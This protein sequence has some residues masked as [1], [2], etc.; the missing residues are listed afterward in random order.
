MNANSRYRRVLVKLSG[1][2]LMG[3]SRDTFDHR[4]MDGL[5]RELQAAHVAG[6]ELAL[7]V[8]GGNI[9]RGG[10]EG[11]RGLE[12]AR[13]DHMGMLATVINSLAIQ[14]ALAS[15]G[16]ESVVQSAIAMPQVAEPFVLRAALQ[17]LAQGRI[18]LFAAGT[19][20]PY[21]TTDTAASLRAV[22]IGADLLLKGTK[23][24]GVYAADPK[25][26]PH[27]E[28]FD[29][30]TFDQVM[31]RK[32]QVMDLTAISLCQANRMPILVFSILERGVLTAIMQ[33]ERRGTLIEEAL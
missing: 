24:D 15:L 8:G 4:F 6:V 16:L 26:H 32:L 23:V 29:R 9:Y 1:E 5:A 7:V 2:A 28:R 33:G 10:T 18:L 21:F 25:I 13:G 30:L 20:N 3:S 31:E 17:A 22:E 12:R 14:N 27:A 19:G 11:A